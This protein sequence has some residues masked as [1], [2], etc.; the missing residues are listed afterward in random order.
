MAEPADR[1][2]R[3]Q[4]ERLQE[5]VGAVVLEAA[6]ERLKNPRQLA[7]KLFNRACYVAHESILVSAGISAVKGTCNDS[8]TAKR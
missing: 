6:R 7:G 8:R 4:A 5:R 1:I 3:T 2:G